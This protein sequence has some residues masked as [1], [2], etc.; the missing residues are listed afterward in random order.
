M[1]VRAAVAVGESIHSSF[2]NQLLEMAA[3]EDH[4]FEYQDYSKLGDFAHEIIEL[5][6]QDCQA[7]NS[8]SIFPQRRSQLPVGRVFEH[9]S[10][11]ILLS[12]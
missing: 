4:I 5:I 3:D 11:F 6:K 7:L 10:D 12:L 9:V 1:L 8:D 2:K